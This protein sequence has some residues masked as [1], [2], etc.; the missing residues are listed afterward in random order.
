MR[1][2]VGRWWR[3]VGGRWGKD[4]NCVKKEANRKDVVYLIFPPGGQIREER[5]LTDA[6]SRNFGLVVLVMYAFQMNL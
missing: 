1:C 3:W 5:F 4:L 6:I 2:E